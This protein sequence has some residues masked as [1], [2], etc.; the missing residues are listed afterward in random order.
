MQELATYQIPPP[1]KQGAVYQQNVGVE[2]GVSGD[3]G[4]TVITAKNTN[5]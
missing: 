1:D 4:A 5:V 2:W 3:R